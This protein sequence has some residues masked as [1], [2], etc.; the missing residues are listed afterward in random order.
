MD[1]SDYNINIIFDLIDYKFIDNIIDFSILKLGGYIKYVNRYDKYYELKTGGILVK[2][3]CDNGKWFCLIKNYFNNF[4]KV[5][6]KSN[7]IFYKSNIHDMKR[8]NM[9]KLLSY[10]TNN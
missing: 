6:F 3:L 10:F 1:I 9:E 8:E 2:I 5:G 7:Y 4:Y